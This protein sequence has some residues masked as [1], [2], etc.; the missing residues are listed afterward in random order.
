MKVLDDGY[1]KRDFAIAARQDLFVIA[2]KEG[3]LNNFCLIS[4]DEHGIAGHQ[5]FVLGMD[6]GSLR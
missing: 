4:F 3:R 2:D 5:G 1:K 6:R